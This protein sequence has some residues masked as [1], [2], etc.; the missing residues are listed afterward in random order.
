M[1]INYTNTPC[2]SVI[3]L[4]DYL[5]LIVDFHEEDEAV[6]HYGFY[7]GDFNLLEFEADF[8]QGFARRMKIV[9]CGDYSTA[10]GN[11]TVPAAREGELIF[12][13]AD[14]FEPGSSEHECDVFHVYI[15][16][17]GIQVKVGNNEI[18]KNI[19]SGSVFFSLDTDNVIQ[20]VYISDMTKQQI[21]HFNSLLIIDKDE[22]F[23]L[24]D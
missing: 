19:R 2:E 3:R 18:C 15:F 14:F 22:S 12:S 24:S 1:K 8:A 9:Y 20:D 23:N 5:P 21:K 13:G 11:I 6:K 16:Q 7:G 4:D 10:A 17:D